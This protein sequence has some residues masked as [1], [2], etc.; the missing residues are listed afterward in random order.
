[1]AEDANDSQQQINI[2]FVFTHIKDNQKVLYLQL[3]SNDYLQSH[4]A[5]WPFKRYIIINDAIHRHSH[6]QKM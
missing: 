6:V 3:Q 2:N 1:M 4:F 5:T